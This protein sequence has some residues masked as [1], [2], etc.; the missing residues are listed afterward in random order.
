MT[1][2]NEINF[3]ETEHTPC[4]NGGHSSDFSELFEQLKE[5]KATKV[6]TPYVNKGISYIKENPIQSS[7]IALGSG[8]VLG[9]LLNRNK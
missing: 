2:E 7:L 6:V 1:E 3:E 5:S 8:L 4:S 9:L